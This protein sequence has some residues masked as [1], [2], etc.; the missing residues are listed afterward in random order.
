M[1]N[2]NLD[3]AYQNDQNQFIQKL[4]EFHQLRG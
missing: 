2:K 3:K 1:M 4:K